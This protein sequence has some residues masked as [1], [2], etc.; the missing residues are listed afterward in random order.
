M[1]IPIEIPGLDTI[2]PKLPEG[3]L[4]VAESGPDPAKS[5]FLRKLCLTALRLD[6]SVT[7]V[8]SRGEDEI[9]SLFEREGG[10]PNDYSEALQ[11]F[12]RDSL[13]TVE[14]F[15]PG[16][17]VFALDSFT[18]LTLDLGSTQ[19]ATLLRRLRSVCLEHR[20]TVL[21]ATD[22]GMQ[23]PS[24][25]SVTNHLSDAVVQFHS[26]EGPE[27]VVRFLRIPKWTDGRFVDRNIYYDFDGRRMAIDLRR[28]VI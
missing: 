20:T 19:L 21:L 6:S 9:H 22:R 3:Q 5:F 18:L 28:R 23:P 1:D 25:E 14:E 15:R 4:V 24:S 11:I 26:K 7:F 12:A 2:V 13:Q 17:G 16:N 10:L 27:G 8:T